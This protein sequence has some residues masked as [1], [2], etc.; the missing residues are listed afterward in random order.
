MGK[1][2]HTLAGLREDLDQVT[3]VL[4]ITPICRAAVERLSRW[5]EPDAAAQLVSEVLAAWEKAQF[6][7]R[8]KS[9]I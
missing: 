8:K 9:P 3:H 2:P 4:E 7:Q 6:D 1:I 5:M